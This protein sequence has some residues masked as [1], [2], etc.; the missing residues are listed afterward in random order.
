MVTFEGDRG[1][2][3]D[4]FLLNGSNVSDGANPTDNVFNSTVANLGAHVHAK[5]PDFVNQLGFDIDQIDG[6]G[7]IPNNATSA[8][9]EYTTQG[10]VY[11]PTVLTFAVDVFEPRLTITKSADDANGALLAPGDEIE[12]TIHVESVGSDTATDIVLVDPIPAGTTYVANSTTIESGPNA[13][14]VTDAAGDDVGEFDGPGNQLVLRLGVGAT[15]AAGG[16]LASSTS[17]EIRFRVTLDVVAPGTTIENQAV[18]SYSGET[19]GGSFNESSDSDG[20]TPG[21]QP[22]E[23][24]V[25]SP[26]VAADDSGT[27]DEGT[28]VDVDVLANDDDPDGWVDLDPASVAVTGGPNHGNTSVDPITGIVTYT[29]DPNYNGTDTFTYEVCDLSGVCDEATVDI[30]IGAVAD[31]PVA[32][33]DSA[34]TPQGQP[35]EV[36]VLANDDDPDGWSD[37]DPA[38]VTVT[39]APGH[40]QTSVDPITGKVTYTP[41]PGFSGPD[42]FSYEICDMD[43]HCDTATVDIDVQSAGEPPDA[44][45]DSASTQPGVPVL[46]DV[47]DNDVPGIDELDPTSVSIVSGPDHGEL[48]VDPATGEITYTPDPGYTGPDSFTYEV[49]DTGGQCATAVVNITVILPDTAVLGAEELQPTFTWLRALLIAVLPFTLLAVGLLASWRHRRVPRPRR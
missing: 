38:T 32:A 28:P 18:V 46:I 6:T 13:G 21:D 47:L 37:L 36:D 19:S 9:L 49:C 7:F 23:M 44:T 34:T 12:Y 14:A 45:N 3:G 22:A 39:G 16:N 11:Y 27:T 29:P 48:T 41:D 20:N 26:P 31:P 5:N 2:V 1:L 33:D 42:A 8:T 10:D 25:Q 40:G 15:S 24:D 43:G 17:T 30:T 4:Q 35:V